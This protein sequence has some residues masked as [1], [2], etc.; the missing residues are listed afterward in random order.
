MNKIIQIRL[1]GKEYE[2]L[3]GLS[4]GMHTTV[5]ELLREEIKI[6]IDKQAERME[7]EF[8]KKR[9]EEKVEDY[10]KSI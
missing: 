2:H 1:S 10:A 7:E 6:I 9:K 5:E 8:V 3:E 4:R